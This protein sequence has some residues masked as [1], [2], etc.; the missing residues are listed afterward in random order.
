MGK[1]YRAGVG[2]RAVNT[3][4]RRL[5]FWGRGPKHLHVLT[6]AGRKSGLERSVPVDVMDV[7][8]LPHLVAPYGE[9]NW[10]RNLRVAKKATLRRGGEVHVYEAFE[11]APEEAVQVIREYVRL[12]PVTKAYWNVS[13]NSAHEEILKDAKTHPVFR[14]NAG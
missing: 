5:A 4:F 10:V 14:L 9:V 13:H 7:N 6:V 1:K 11:L 8:G 12:V 2:Q 3:V